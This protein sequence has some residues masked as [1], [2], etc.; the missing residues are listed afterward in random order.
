MDEILKQTDTVYQIFKKREFLFNPDQAKKKLIQTVAFLALLNAANHA[1]ESRMGQSTINL[2]TGA[3]LWVN[4]EAFL[5]KVLSENVASLSTE[6]ER[7]TNLVGQFEA[8]GM[9]LAKLSEEKKQQIKE[10]QEKFQ[11]LIQS[12]LDLI[13]E[14]N[15][16]TEETNRRLAQNLEE[17]VGKMETARHIF[18]LAFR[19]L[20]QKCK[21]GD[22]KELKVAVET[23]TMLCKSALPKGATYAEL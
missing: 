21:E 14:T 1:R 6:N 10:Q 9:D 7:L 11:D 13:E 19:E 3:V 4:Q 23:Y 2:T 20:T 22:L 8:I 5:H 15:K 18:T 17:S 12:L 16:H